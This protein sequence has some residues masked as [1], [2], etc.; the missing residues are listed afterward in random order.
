MH[1]RNIICVAAQKKGEELMYSHS[2]WVSIEASRLAQQGKYKEAAA[3]M[4]TLGKG[5]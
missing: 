3:L 4:A 1:H 2:I 5:K